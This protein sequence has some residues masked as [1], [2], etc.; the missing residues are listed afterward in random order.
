[1]IVILIIGALETISKGLVKVPENLYG[2]EANHYL[3]RFGWILRIVSFLK[4]SSKSV[5]AISLV[6]LLQ[7]QV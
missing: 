4:S 3:N 1:M 6:F 2:Y 7:G 5:Q